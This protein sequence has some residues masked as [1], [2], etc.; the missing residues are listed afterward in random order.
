MEKTFRLTA[1]A[2]AAVIGIGVAALVATI[3]APTPTV[4]GS[5]PMA[6]LVSVL[7]L[8]LVGYGTLVATS[9][10]KVSRR[11]DDLDA[12]NAELEASLRATLVRSL[13]D[14]LTRVGNR[15]AFN[16]A[17]RSQL[18][19]RKRREIAEPLSVVMLDLDDFGVINKDLGWG[20]GDE[21]LRTVAQRMVNVVRRESDVVSHAPTNAG[22]EKP[23]GFRWGGEEF[24]LLLPGT[25]LE[26]AQT[27]ADNVAAALRDAPVVVFD[28]NGQR[29]EI[30]VTASMGI[31]DAAEVDH[32]LASLTN[33]LS[34]RLHAAK[35]QGKDRAVATSP[36]LVAV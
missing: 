8:A 27:V 12:A 20:A 23:D 3:T 29:H 21:V 26:G 36:S 14:E 19:S 33:T 17:L 35:A 6:G 16:E 22:D 1:V 10:R 5:M 25:D 9:G 31:V 30:T 24:F 11:F 34:A 15:V 13:T 2:T 32:D 4:S 28:T 18:G 7:S